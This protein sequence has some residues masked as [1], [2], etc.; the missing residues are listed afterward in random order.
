MKFT[1]QTEALRKFAL[2]LVGTYSVT[3]L[4]MGLAHAQAT[5]PAAPE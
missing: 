4:A 5:E 3:A 1:D 2:R